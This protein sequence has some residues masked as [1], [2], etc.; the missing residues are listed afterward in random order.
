[1]NDLLAAAL[2]RRGYIML[3]WAIFGNKITQGIM[4]GE[5]ERKKLDAAL[6]DFGEALPFARPQLK[7]AIWLEM[8]R[9]QGILQ[10]TTLSLSLVSQAANMVEAGSNLS[11]PHEQILLEGALN[12]LNEGMY[13]LRKTASLIALGRT[14]TAI[15]LLDDLEEL[16][17]GKGI[18]RNQARRLAYIDVLWAEASLGT[19]DYVTAA[20]RAISAFQTLRDIQTIERIALINQIYKQLAAK[21]GSHPEVKHL[22]KLL[23]DYY[24]KSAPPKSR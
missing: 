11:N 10:Q 8:S 14:T 21:H 23:G 19:R 1:M 7:G 15:D 6:T 4:N 20:T 5:P 3:E 22:G 2:Y 17:N 24:Q 9:I 12:G 13:L 16:K 18:A